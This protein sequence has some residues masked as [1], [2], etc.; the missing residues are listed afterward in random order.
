MTIRNFIRTKV[1]KSKLKVEY[2]IDGFFYK[3]EM[4]ISEDI[5]DRVVKDVAY[6]GDKMIA[7]RT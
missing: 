4:D 7:I 3:N 6:F 5:K 2:V 1:I